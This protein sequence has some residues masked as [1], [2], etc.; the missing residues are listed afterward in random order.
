LNQKK[1]VIETNRF[2]LRQ[3]IV[4]DAA[5]LFALDSDPEVIRYTGDK[6]HESVEAAA[7]FIEHYYPSL[8]VGTGRWAII[9]RVNGEW[10]GWCG[11]KAE[12]EAGCFDIGYRLM[13]V[14]WG[15]GVATETAKA[16]VHYA[17]THLHAQQVIGRVM[18]ENVASKNVLEKIG[19]KYSG[20][21]LCE[22]HPAMVFT[23]QRSEYLLLS[24]A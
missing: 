5:F 15:R 8:P 9:D 20:E 14:H 18:H 1:P 16:C 22:H 10:L 3:M 11:V 21:E 2:T 23:I 12:G 7:E 17:F 4:Q 6:S 19:F 13:R 24:G